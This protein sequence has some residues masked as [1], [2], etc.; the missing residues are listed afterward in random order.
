GVAAP[1]TLE[2][3]SECLEMNDVGW[4]AEDATGG[5]IFTTIGRAAYV[6]VSVPS[7]YPLGTGA[8][9]DLG[10]AVSTHDAS[11]TPCAG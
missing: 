10:T 2:R 1:P 8:L 7:Q 9:V 6:E 11:I 4:Y 3:D 5:K